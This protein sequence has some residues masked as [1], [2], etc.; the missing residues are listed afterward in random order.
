[1]I[2]LAGL[3]K[4]MNELNHNFT[5]SSPQKKFSRDG[6]LFAEIDL[7]LENYDEVMAVEAKARFKLG[8]MNKF[9]RRIELLRENESITGVAGKTIYAA[10]A[11]I[12]F[13]PP[14]RLLAI[15]KGMYLINIDQDSDNIEVIPPDNGKI[16]RW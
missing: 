6:E 7:L 16:G 8:D 11:A 1:M 15:E 10:A 4:K 14:A 5:M 3:L 2:L 13:D 9:L 12:S